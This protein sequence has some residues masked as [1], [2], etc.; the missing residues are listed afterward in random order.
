L[1]V[2]V[3]ADPQEAYIIVIKYDLF[4]SAAPASLTL[5]QR[6]KGERQQD[7]R[8]LTERIFDDD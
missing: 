6:Q 3:Q 7:W 8:G 5:N 4:I 2:P 1:G